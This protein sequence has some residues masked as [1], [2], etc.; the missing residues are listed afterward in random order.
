MIGA[1]VST[2]SFDISFQYGAHFLLLRILSQSEFNVDLYNIIRKWIHSYLSGREYKNYVVN[3]AKLSA[4][5][6]VS[7]VLYLALRLISC[8]QMES[9]LMTSL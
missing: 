3:G 5:P 9:W 4:L 2:V 8:F 1:E 6:V 7:R